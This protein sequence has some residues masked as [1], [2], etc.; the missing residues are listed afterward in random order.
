MIL[1]ADSGSTKTDWRLIGAAGISQ[2]QT[3]GINPYFQ[4]SGDISQLLRQELSPKLDLS[5]VTAVHFYGAGC[6]APEKADTVRMA[7]QEEL[8]KAEIHV[9][10]DM[11][12]AV[13][14]LCGNEPGIA[15][16]LGTGSNSCY[17]DG[18]AIMENVPSYGYL[19][20]DHGS[21]ANIGKRLV[22]AWVDGKL[23]PELKKRFEERSGN[24]R[25]QILE[26]VYRKPFPNRF[27]AAYSKFVFQHLSH[28]FMVALV[29][30][31]FHAFF[32]T[33]VEKYAAHKN[34]PVHAVGSVAFFYHAILKSVAE[35][36]G[37]TMGRILE[38]PIAAL[39]LYHQESLQ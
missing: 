32:S 27:L 14:A 10:T 29:K 17:Y 3:T 5:G 9:G 1:I 15:C 30:E 23:P 7:L 26:N 21:G 38:T 6:A 20:G 22:Q 24:A 37:I 28:P 8:E 34:V 13:K 11:L 19:F 39:T 2:C 36:K 18:T 33:Q 31:S 25:E 16:I 35:E 4:S 12:G